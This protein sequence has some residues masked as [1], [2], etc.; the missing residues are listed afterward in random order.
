MKQRTRITA[1]IMIGLSSYNVFA[2]LCSV[3]M[4]KSHGSLF[5]SP[6]LAFGAILGAL[7]NATIL[8][9]WIYLFKNRIWAWT[10]LVWLTALHC[11]G[12]LFFMFPLVFFADLPLLSVGFMPFPFGWAYIPALVLLL[13]DKPFEWDKIQIG[14][15]PRVQPPGELKKRTR[16][17]AWIALV[18]S[19]ISFIEL[20]LVILAYRH[21]PGSLISGLPGALLWVLWIGLIGKRVWAWWA[22]VAAYAAMSVWYVWGIAHTP[23]YYSAHHKVLAHSW[24]A[25][26][27][28]SVMLI[29]AVLIPL[30]ALLTDRPLNWA[31][32]QSE[33][34]DPK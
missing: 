24:Y 2:S 22:L 11:V 23:A 29:L 13:K 1:A 18:F 34:R 17:I 14:S 28:G 26:I 8:A 32:P 30:W 33:I 9:G 15:A 4:G 25:M 19:A 31:N 21:K 20:P 6:D 7:A 16:V 27:P 3:L 12:M 5:G 10:M